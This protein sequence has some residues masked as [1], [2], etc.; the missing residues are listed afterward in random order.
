MV[1]EYES[2]GR[3][4]FECEFCGFGYGDLETAERCEQYCYQHGKPSPALS[5]KHL[6]K[7]THLNK[8]LNSQT[9]A[10]L[11]EF[12]RYE[13]LFRKLE[14]NR[15]VDL[16]VRLLDIG[17]QVRNRTRTWVRQDLLDIASLKGLRPRML[18][19]KMSSPTFECRLDSALRIE[20]EPSRIDALCNI[21]GMR[22][23]LASMVLMFTWPETY[24]FMDYHTCN[25][26]RQLGFDFPRKHC[27]SKFTVPQLLTYL[28]YVR[29]LQ[30]Y[31]G[32]GAMEITKALYAFDRIGQ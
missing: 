11:Q 19:M 6:H 21:R 32:V 17:K 8:V 18:M 20:D 30:E 9:S 22:P 25:A 23:V 15:R 10:F 29:R 2:G 14:T 1:N 26:L 7:P 27:T 24:G 4:I 16:E 13:A 3:V 31:K 28:R 5:Q 12:D